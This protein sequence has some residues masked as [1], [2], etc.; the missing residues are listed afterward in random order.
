MDISVQILAL[1]DTKVFP[2]TAEIAPRVGW[3]RSMWARGDRMHQLYY[4][5]MGRYGYICLSQGEG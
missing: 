3:E 5:T 4:P 1:E 2:T